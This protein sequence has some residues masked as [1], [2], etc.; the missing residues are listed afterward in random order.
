MTA[1]AAAPPQL[2]FEGLVVL[3][4]T[5]IYNGPY[6][7]FLLAQ[8]GA[9]VIKIE[10]PRGEHLRTRFRS[11]GVTEPF[12]VLN[13]NKRCVTLDL[14]NPAGIEVFLELLAKADVVVENFAPGVMDRLGLGDAVL[15]ARN[16]RLIIA[17]GSGYGSHGPYRDYPAMDVTVQAMSGVLAVT[18]LPDGT[19]VKAG[20]AV[21]DFF[22]GVHL[23]GAIVTALYRRALTGR[24]SSVEVS[25]MS[26]V[27]PSLL[28]NLGL[29][30]E[31]VKPT[32]RA[33]NR[34]GGLLMAPYNVYP[35]ADGAIAILSV[36]Q[37]HWVAIAATLE[38]PEWCDDPRFASHFARVKNMDELDGLIGEQTSHLPKDELCTRLVRARV[39]CAPVRELAEV[40][41]DPHLH[42]TGMLRWFEHPEHGRIL[43]HGSPL[44][45][46]EEAPAAYAPSQRLGEDTHAVLEELCGLDPAQISALEQRGAFTAQK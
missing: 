43:V 1:T 9:S 39:P 42:A 6:A 25:M 37:A 16:P 8:A 17:S 44:V 3:D 22:G 12:A 33:G 30:R 38:H 35:T 28:S 26:A 7:T 34:H 10:P 21:S 14:K 2:P 46:K 5:Q 18:G 23:Y 40:I 29:A 31:G 11:P 4:L 27:Y 13:A 19:P 24:G 20:P 45:F 15:R 36:T 32:P 41:E